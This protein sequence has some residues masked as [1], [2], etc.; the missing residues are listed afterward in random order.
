MTTRTQGCPAANKD[1]FTQYG[2]I[3]LDLLLKDDLLKPEVYKPGE[4]R[5]ISR[6]A[7]TKKG[8]KN[9]AVR[10]EISASNKIGHGVRR[11]NHNMLEEE[12][13]RAQ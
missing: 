8:K 10:Y 9:T 13:G 12:R 1:T 4:P 7:K 5:T 2:V 11:G 6:R 3:I